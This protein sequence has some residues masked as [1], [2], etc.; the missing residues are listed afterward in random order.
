MIPHLEAFLKMNEQ[1]NMPMAYIASYVAKYIAR[2]G[3]K[4]DFDG[5]PAEL[6]QEVVE[7]IKGYQDR[8]RL[9]HRFE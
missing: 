4:S 7:T 3:D 1:G 5:L 6:R 2:E 8:G 9:A